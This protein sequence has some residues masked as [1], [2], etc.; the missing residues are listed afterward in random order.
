MPETS[1]GKGLHSIHENNRFAKYLK[2][3]SLQNT[4]QKKKYR[5]AAKLFQINDKIMENHTAPFI[6]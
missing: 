4:S 1:R 3:S 2:I 5:E 6:H